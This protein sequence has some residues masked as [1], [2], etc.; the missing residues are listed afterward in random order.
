MESLTQLMETKKKKK[1]RPFD[2]R[3]KQELERGLTS[4]LLFL[5]M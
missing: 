4:E 1:A 5:F 3:Q 2:F